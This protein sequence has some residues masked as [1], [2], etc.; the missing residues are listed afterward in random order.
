VAQGPKTELV[1]VSG[2]M[3]Q[4]IEDMIASLSRGVGDCLENARTAKPENAF[5][6]VRSSERNDATRI[7]STTAELLASIAKLKGE[8]RHDYRITRTNQPSAPRVR[9]PDPPG[10]TELVELLSQEEIDALSEEE[11]R[12]Y[13]AQL[14]PPPQNRGSNKKRA[15]A[16][17]P[18]RPDTLKDLAD[19]VERVEK[20][21]SATPH[22]ENR[23]SNA[24]A[25]KS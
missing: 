17:K 19:E 2:R 15:D 11:Y 6:N 13:V 25:G 1:G 12:A 23:G 16:P 10:V 9:H 4:S 3:Q 24:D 7:V 22:P 5:D 21:M 8:F 20:I 14:T 18:A